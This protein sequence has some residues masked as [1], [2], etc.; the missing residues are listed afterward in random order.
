MSPTITKNP[1]QA[2]EAPS[3]SRRWQRE[4]IIAGILL[5]VLLL[6]VVVAAF[7]AP[8]WQALGTALLFLS[9]ATLVLL[10]LGSLVITLLV[11]V[12]SREDAHV[13]LWVRRLTRLGLSWIVLLVALGAVA[14]GSQWHAST[15]PV[16]GANG[17]P[18]PGSIATLEPVTLN[19]SREWITIR[20]TNVHNPVLLFLMGGPGAGG[21]PDQGF[22]APLESHFVV[23]NWDQPGTGKSYGAVPTSALTPERYVDDAHALVLQLRARFHQQKIYVLGSSWGSILGIM[24]VQ[25]YPE[26][27]AAYIGHGQMVNTTQNDQMGYQFALKYA[28]QHGNTG[29]VNTLQRNGPPP[30]VGSGMALKYAAYMDVLQAAMGQPSLTL[31]IPLLPQFAPEY[32]LLDRVNYVRGFLETFAVVYPQLQRLD[33]MT[34]ANKLDV[35]VYLL[36]GRADVNAMASLTEQYFNLLQSPH[37]E[38]IWFKSGHSMTDSDTGQFIDVMVNDVLAQTQH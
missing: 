30:Y 13:A 24:L 34:Q 27:F 14:V 5:L 28:A 7:G 31:G 9:I 16:L 35:P 25:Q 33:F 10:T 1:P 2:H 18:L 19:G 6:V 26:L 15:P 29:T 37:K 32:G 21:F 17:Q 12:T 8:L 20:G 11:A 38:L 23:V 4:T 22:L 3:V 36:V